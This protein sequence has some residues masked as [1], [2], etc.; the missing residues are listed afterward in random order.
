[1]NKTATEIKANVGTMDY[2]S[3]DAIRDLCDVVSVLQEEQD[4]SAPNGV[5]EWREKYHSME[6]DRDLWKETAE[7]VDSLRNERDKTIAGMQLTLTIREREA[8]LTKA[9]EETLRRSIKHLTNNWLHE[10]KLRKEE[11]CC[12]TERHTETAR[13]KE[14]IDKFEAE[15]KRLRDMLHTVYRNLFGY[16]TDEKDRYGCPACQAKKLL[17]AELY[18]EEAKQAFKGAPVTLEV[19]APK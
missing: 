8:E 15:I 9:T 16:I 18:P 2:C 19:S 5:A 17:K 10:Q 1:M 3:L 13:H 6:R 11:M 4:E 12:A 7:G 14:A